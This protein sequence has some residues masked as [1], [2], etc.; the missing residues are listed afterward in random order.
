MSDTPSLSEN[1]KGEKK[2]EVNDQH[3]SHI[4]VFFSHLDFTVGI[5]LKTSQV[6][7]GKLGETDFAHFSIKR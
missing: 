3:Y 5:V 2:P 6:Y 4:V 1:W 7:P